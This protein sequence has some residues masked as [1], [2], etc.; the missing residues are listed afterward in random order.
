MLF[1]FYKYKKLATRAAHSFFSSECYFVYLFSAALNRLYIELWKVHLS[2][3]HRHI[4]S[5]KHG[6]KKVSLHSA[7]MYCWAWPISHY[8]ECR[9]A[10]C[11]GAM[12]AAVFGDSVYNSVFKT[13][14]VGSSWLMRLVRE[15]FF[16]LRKWPQ[17][18]DEQ[19]LD[20][21]RLKWCLH[22][23]LSSIQSWF[24]DLKRLGKLWLILCRRAL[25]IRSECCCVPH[26]QT[27][28]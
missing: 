15:I 7:Q 25:L 19:T 23:R 20:K 22:R 18:M 13:S 3:N 5:T 8:A 4:V 28:V 24:C 27:D 16:W 1:L 6:Y 12:S 26:R 9:Y 21:G 11:R 2:N 14:L 10:E 17:G